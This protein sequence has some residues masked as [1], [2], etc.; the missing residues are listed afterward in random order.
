MCLFHGSR[1]KSALAKMSGQAVMS[2]LQRRSREC[3]LVLSS[4]VQDSSLG[5]GDSHREDSL[6]QLTSD[7]PPQVYLE[8]Y[9]PGV[10][11]FFQVEDFAVRVF[12]LTVLSW[13]PNWINLVNNTKCYCRIKSEQFKNTRMSWD[14]DPYRLGKSAVSHMTGQHWTPRTGHLKGQIGPRMGH[15]ACLYFPSYFNNFPS[16]GNGI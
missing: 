4:P 13:N 8:S 11:R 9:L 7:N 5:N 6:L 2:H 10:S 15:D 14:P 12:N 3:W 1:V 16:S